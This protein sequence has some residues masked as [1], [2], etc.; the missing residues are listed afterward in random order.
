MTNLNLIHE[1][2]QQ[3]SPFLEELQLYVRFYEQRKHITTK[4]SYVHTHTKLDQYQQGAR[5]ENFSA[6][7]RFLT[8]ARWLSFIM[9]LKSKELINID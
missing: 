5:G 7:C 6:Q 3:K 1:I 4:E 9:L 8:P 2:Q